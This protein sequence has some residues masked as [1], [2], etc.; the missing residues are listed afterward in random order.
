MSLVA[1]SLKISAKVVED[2]L[3]EKLRHVSLQNISLVKPY[4]CLAPLRPF[5]VLDI[6]HECDVIL[7]LPG[8]R[9]VLLM[10]GD[11]GED[12]VL[13]AGRRAAFLAQLHEVFVVPLAIALAH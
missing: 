8:M 3:P 4:A 13:N 9:S 1:N 7:R 6:L 12:E 11:G 10:E 2:V 5:D